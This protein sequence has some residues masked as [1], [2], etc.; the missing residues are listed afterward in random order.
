MGEEVSD[1]FETFWS[2]QRTLRGEKRRLPVGLA[3]PFLR[4]RAGWPLALAF[5][6]SNSP[7]YLS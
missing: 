5:V 4:T 6:T 1:H 3:L 7:R 2:L